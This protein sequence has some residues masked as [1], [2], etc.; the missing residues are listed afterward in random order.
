MTPSRLSL[1]CTRWGGYGWT[2]GVRRAASVNPDRT[3]GAGTVTRLTD[4]RLGGTV[5]GVD[6]EKEHQGANCTRFPSPK[7]G[8]VSPWQAKC[9][10]SDPCHACPWPYPAYSRLPDQTA[11]R[12]GQ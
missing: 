1:N 12:I 7:R 11:G 9:H 8:P 2:N 5:P 10:L 3:R 6:P 4:M